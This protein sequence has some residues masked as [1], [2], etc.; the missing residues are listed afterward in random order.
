MG[1]P[2]PAGRL[3]RDHAAMSELVLKNLAKAYGGSPI[4]SGLDL[5]VESG[6]FIV[7][8]GPSG[9]GKSTLLRLI[10]GLEDASEGQVFLGGEDVTRL[11]P[12]RRSVAMVFQNYAL[13]PHMTVA[14]NI[15]FSL[16]LSGVSKAARRTKVEEVAQILRLQDLLDRKPRA[17][18][19]GQ[20]QRVAIGRAIRSEEHTSE[21]QSP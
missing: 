2:G 20:R 10:A 21:L 11:P 4:I 18:S 15:G 1:R 7:C 16:R 6:E 17:L 12:A 5:T 8:V 13:Y 19:G 14:E 9:C 3:D